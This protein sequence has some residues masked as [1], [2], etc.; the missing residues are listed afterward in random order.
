MKPNNCKKAVLFLLGERGFHVL[1][2]LVLNGYTN[3]IN[4]V[5]IGKDNGVLNDYYN[6]IKIFVEDQNIPWHDRNDSF[7]FSQDEIAIVISWKWLIKQHGIPIL[8]L[9]DSILP[10]YRGFNPLVT[11][12]I[13]GD[14][15]VG[16][17]AIIAS[18]GI[19][20]GPILNQ[21]I[22]KIKYPIQII[23]VI[24][25][26]K[27]LYMELV[28]EIFE[29]FLL[30]K[31]EIIGEIQNEDI[32]SFSLWRDD[33]DY[34]IDWS[35]SSIELQRFVDAVGSP[36]DGAKTIIGSVIIKINQAQVLP[37]LNIINRT[38]GKLLRISS[39]GEEAWVVCKEGI[40]KIKKCTSLDGKPYRFTKLRSRLGSF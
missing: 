5:I 24:E 38:P 4:K 33:Y 14:N 3:Y 12:L 40:L 17:S 10:K 21:K 35:K 37:D 22:I 20:E 27:V 1:E 8:V 29:K 19:D 23:E 28:F 16:V 18:E 26:I 36:Y 11:A 25:R 34:F 32:A 13:N 6:E 7:I 31:Q 15:E 39:C 9:H 30:Q 2:N